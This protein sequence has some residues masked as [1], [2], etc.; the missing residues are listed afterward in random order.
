MLNNF[1]FYN[2]IDFYWSVSYNL[3][4]SKDEFSYHRKC[5][6]NSNVHTN[7]ISKSLTSYFTDSTQMT[8]SYIPFY[9]CLLMSISHNPGVFHI[10]NINLKISISDFNPLF[11]HIPTSRNST[12]WSHY[13]LDFFFLSIWTWLIKIPFRFINFGSKPEVIMNNCISQEF[14]FEISDIDNR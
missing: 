14:S 3:P 2:K 7:D 10:I 8:L 4:F 6:G 13:V 5:N 1:Y 9:L 11:F 12:P